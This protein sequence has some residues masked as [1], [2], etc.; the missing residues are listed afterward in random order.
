[1]AGI[2]TKQAEPTEWG[3]YHEEREFAREV[4]DPRL[5]V[6]IARNKQEAE[7]QAGLQGICGPTG[8]W[9]HPLPQTENPRGKASCD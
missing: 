9:A 1:M 3:I 4:G 7:A 2:E 6:V 5:G 8:V